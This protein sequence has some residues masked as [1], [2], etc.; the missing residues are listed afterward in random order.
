[1]DVRRVVPD[2]W[3]SRRWPVE[4]DA[5]ANEDDSLDEALDRSELV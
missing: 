2:A 4:D 3:E 5:A 1:M